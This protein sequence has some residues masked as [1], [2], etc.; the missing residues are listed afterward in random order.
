MAMRPPVRE[1]SKGQSVSIDTNDGGGYTT[2]CAQQ[3]APTHLPLANSNQ[4]NSNQNTG[5]RR[6][7][8]WWPVL[9]TKLL[10][11]WLKQILRSWV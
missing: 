1:I 5:H 10:T 8:E 11:N 3:Y 6:W 7:G 2:M 4:S 9:F